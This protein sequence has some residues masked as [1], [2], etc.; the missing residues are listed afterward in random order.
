MVVED[1]ACGFIVVSVIHSA[2][3]SGIVVAQDGDV[4]KIAYGIAT[5]V[6]QRPVSDDVTE[7]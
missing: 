5:F 4:G 7:A 3:D 6:R 1:I 2:T